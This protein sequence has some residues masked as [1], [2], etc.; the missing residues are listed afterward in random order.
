[1][2][3]GVF[4]KVLQKK[5]W[6]LSPEKWEDLKRWEGKRTFVIGFRNSENMDS[7]LMVGVQ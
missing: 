5:H 1:M 2:W 6:D 3:A 4:G 7:W